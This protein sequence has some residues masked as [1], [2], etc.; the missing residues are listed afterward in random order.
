MQSCSTFK[1]NSIDRL[2]SLQLVLRGMGY[3]RKNLLSQPLWPPAK[4]FIRR[5][6]RAQARVL[7]RRGQH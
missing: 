2:P 3:K 4:D 6:L 7:S 1:E 5:L